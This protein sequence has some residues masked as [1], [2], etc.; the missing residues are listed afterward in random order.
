MK[1]NPKILL[2]ILVFGVGAGLIFSAASSAKISDSNR[3]RS[4]EL[5]YG[6]QLESLPEEADQIQI[7]VPLAKTDRHQQVRTREIQTAYPY[8]ILVDPEYDNDILYLSLERPVP[9][10]LNISIR[11]EAEV[12]E[13]SHPIRGT[14][15]TSPVQTEGVE[16]DLYLSSRSFMVVNGRIQ[17]LAASVTAGKETPLEKARA[18]YDYVIGHMTYEKETPGWGDGDTLRAC[19]LATGNCTDFHSLFI[20]LARASDIPA[21]FRIGLP[22]P[23]DRTEGKIAGYHCWAEFFV[24]GAGWVPVDAS[25][26]WKHRERKEYFFG[27]YDPNRLAVST[28]RDIRLGFE[29]AQGPVNIFFYPRV[30]VDGEL[31]DGVETKFHFQDLTMTAKKGGSD[32]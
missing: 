13:V 28:G 5:T 16:R 20:S 10:Q 15:F 8:Q 29:S 26:A 21:R 9:E 12:R 27:T 7:W 11:Y 2:G 25:E 1:G 31:F 3:V 24:D 14:R 18:I 22:V 6:V 32:A 23:S 19:D 30:E 4:F 17:K